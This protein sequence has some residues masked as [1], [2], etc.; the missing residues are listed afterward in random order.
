MNAT[1]T[2]PTLTE[3]SIVTITGDNRFIG[4]QG[5]VID[6][7]SDLLP[8]EGPIAV[9]FDTE[10]GEHEFNIFGR[11][12]KWTGGIPTKENYKKCYRVIC[13]LPDELRREESFP[14]E[15]IVQREF[16]S[17]WNLIYSFDFP[18]RPGTH[19]C[20]FDQCKSGLLAT[21]LT[22]VN[23]W[24]TITTVYSCTECHKGWHGMKADGV[25][26]KNPLPGAP[27]KVN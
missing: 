6:M 1:E 4:R 7:N 10:I 9:Y 26:Y 5:L 14:L 22:L 11:G 19:V 24:G 23:V 15:T 12:E 3:G 2:A 17:N 16:G 18:L 25:K 8:T 27:L 20:Q 13:F 21:Q